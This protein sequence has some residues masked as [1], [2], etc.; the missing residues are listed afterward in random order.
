MSTRVVSYLPLHLR[1]LMLVV[2]PL[3]PSRGLVRLTFGRE[4]G[5]PKVQL[6][7]I[8]YSPRLG[9]NVL[10]KVTFIRRYLKVD[11]DYLDLCRPSR[12][13][14]D[15]RKICLSGSSLLCTLLRV[16]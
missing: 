5:D 12:R 14:S 9:P 15:V 16:L 4:L 6:P 3:L 7:Y 10:V 1:F 8:G 13:R 11:M 2:R